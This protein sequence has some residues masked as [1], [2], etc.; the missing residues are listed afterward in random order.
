MINTKSK[1]FF[2]VCIGVVVVMLIGF[3]AYCLFYPMN[4]NDK[5]VYIYIDGDD[6][7]DSISTKLSADCH[8]SG[9]QTVMTLSRHCGYTDNIRTGR[10][11]V[12]PSMGALQLFLH[13]RNGQQAP[14][15]FTVPSVRTTQRFAHEVAKR[16]MMSEKE[17]LAILESNDSLS[18]YDQDTFT[19]MS[20]LIPE[21]YEMYWN[22]SPAKFMERMKLECQDFWGRDRTEKAL[23]LG[24]TPLEVSTLASIVEE[25]TA[26]N[27]EK[28]NVA[29]MYY[30]RLRA[31][32]PL[33]ADPTVKYALKQFELRRIYNNMLR[34]DSPYNTYVHTGLPPGP[35]RIPTVASIDAVLNLNHH[36]YYYMCAKEDFSGTHNFARTY[37]EHLQNAAR[38]TAA[39]NARGVK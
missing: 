14:I 11:E 19:V 10:Y 4:G 33:Q 7:I 13:L 36:D 29:G 35:I 17:L 15:M 3:I 21:T 22:I 23:S 1:Y 18:R 30:N 25:E 26:N 2:P 39:L 31:D 28:P 12:T 32:M 24:L 8:S 16:L 37:A 34:I 6:T 27:E 20:M 5:S 38:Y 9:V